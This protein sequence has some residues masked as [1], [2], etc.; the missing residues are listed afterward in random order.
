MFD[1]ITA[2]GATRDIFFIT[3]HS[4]IIP[5]PS[6]I[7]GELLA[8]ILGAK[9]SIETAHISDG[10]G[11]LNAAIAFTR[12]G[13]NAAPYVNIGND[14]MGQQIILELVREGADAEFIWV[15]DKN[16]T[17]ISVILIPEQVSDRTI[18]AYS[19]ANRSLK[20]RDWQKIEDTKW[21]YISPLSRQSPEL[22]KELV[23]FADKKSIKVANNPG[24]G[25]IELGFE[26]MS[27]VL[28]LIEILIV[29]R[30][31]ANLLLRLKYPGIKVFDDEKLAPELVAMG[32]K[33]V[34]VTCGDEGS[35]ATE[36]STTYYQE[37]V[38]VKTVDATGA[39]DAFG[40]TFLAAYFMG[41][42]IQTSMY[43]ASINAA[44]V[45]SKLGAQEGLLRMDEIRRIAL[46]IA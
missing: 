38:P 7:E 32:P 11:A 31:E 27:E 36:D 30:T 19:G 22:L 24:V 26:Y 45:V 17:G 37:A 44:S 12:L 25:Q 18:L 43:M 29:N 1:V 10:G 39:G 41:Y 4:R 14:E 40:A 28:P 42:D 9:V 15:D 13:L 35:Y 20:V 8:F 46:K 6:S 34:V 5:D 3:G 23:G 2:G 21:L 16:R 33:I